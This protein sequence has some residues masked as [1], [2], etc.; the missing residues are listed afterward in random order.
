MI[1]SGVML[2]FVDKLQDYLTL[3]GKFIVIVGSVQGGSIPILVVL[4]PFDSEFT[5]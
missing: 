3:F 5:I 2:S 4:L 1:K